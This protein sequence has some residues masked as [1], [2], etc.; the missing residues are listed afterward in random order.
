MLRVN[1]GPVMIFRVKLIDA[2]KPLTDNELLAFNSVCPDFQFKIG[3][4]KARMLELA[5]R[6]GGLDDEQLAKLEARLAG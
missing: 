1:K 3:D 2:L 5:R 6:V 4:T